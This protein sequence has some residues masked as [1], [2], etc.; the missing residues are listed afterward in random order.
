MQ[1]NEKNG[2]RERPAYRFLYAAARK[3]AGKKPD[4]SGKSAFSP[5]FFRVSVDRAAKI[6]VKYLLY[7]ETGCEKESTQYRC[8]TESLAC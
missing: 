5:S 4:K 8:A 1:S 2:A 3:G 6:I 7:G